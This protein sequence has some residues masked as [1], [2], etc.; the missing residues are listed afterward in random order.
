MGRSDLIPLLFALFAMGF[1]FMAMEILFLRELL[2]TLGGTIYASSATFAAVM[3]GLFLGS[4]IFGCLSSKVK[5]AAFVLALSALALGGLS[6]FLIPALRWCGLIESWFS[7]YALSFLLILIPS[8]AAG[9]PLPLA[10]ET[11]G[12]V[13]EKNRPG[14]RAGLFYGAGTLGAL[15]AALALPFAALPHLGSYQSSLLAGLAS[16]AGGL[17]LLRHL[18]RVRRALVILGLAAACLFVFIGFS[19][20]GAWLDRLSAVRAMGSR[21]PALGS[22]S[23]H[24]LEDSPYQRIQIIGDLARPEASG[25]IRTLYLDGIAQS[26]V[27]RQPQYR[28]WVYFALLPHPHPENVLVIGCGDGDFIVSILA[29][30]RVKRIDQVEIDP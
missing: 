15:V 20:A 11:T 22:R 13:S 24:Y 26:S 9:G 8:I 14:F 7:R 29:D 12:A 16:L 25:K 5:S 18:G 30:R 6:L 4:Q 23:R 3:L 28:E 1:T 21:D 27:P 2:I 10:V 19:K 17:I